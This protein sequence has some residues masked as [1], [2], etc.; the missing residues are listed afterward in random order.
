MVKAAR[1]IDPIVAYLTI[2]K[3]G[4]TSVADL[5]CMRRV[6]DR[7]SASVAAGERIIVVLSAMGNATDQLVDLAYRAHDQP[8][9]EAYDVLLATGEQ[10]S[11]ALFCMLARARGLK[12]RSYMGW[13][14]GIVTN[15]RH[16]KAK[17]AHIETA[18]L[19]RDVEQGVLPVVA[20]FQGVSAARRL[21]TLGRGGSDTTAVALA[22]ALGADVC[23]IYTDVEGVYTSDPRVVDGARLLSHITFEEMLELASLGTHVLQTRAIQF[24]SRHCMAIRVRST[25]KPDQIGTYISNEEKRMEQALISG[26]SLDRDQ[27]RLSLLGVPFQCGVVHRMI[28]GISDAGIDIDMIVQSTPNEQE[29]IDISFTVHP[30]AY[31][32]AQTVLRTIATELQAR[33]LLH[34]DRVAKLSIVGMGMHTHAGV[35]AKM[36]EVLENSGIAI[37]L[38]STSEIK[39]SALIDEKYLELGARLLHSA[40]EL[41]KNAEES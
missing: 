31:Q 15:D 12:V 8:D 4:G 18:M 1:R 3:F 9:P 30:S 26:V 7:V 10:V 32:Q 24:A 19:W 35:A 13:Q 27:A 28:R 40:F 17:I 34:S 39:I 6:V 37:Q 41:E 38:I 21:T 2:Q 16:K 22:V 5:D 14:A 25:F 11:V 36:F 23:E 29:T 20:G 33:T